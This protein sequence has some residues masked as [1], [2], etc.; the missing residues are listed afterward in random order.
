MSLSVEQ[1]RRYDTV[2][3][4][5]AKKGIGLVIVNQDRQLWVQQD[6]GSRAQTGRTDGQL[7]IPFETQKVGEPHW[8]N[9]LGALPEVFDDETLRPV[10]PRLYT[11]DTYQSSPMRQYLGNGPAIEYSLAVAVYDGPEDL[12]RP[13]MTEEAQPFG[14]MTPGEMLAM[15]NVRPLAYDAITYLQEE[16]VIKQK[17]AEYRDLRHP[18]ELFV[19]E[20]FVLSEFHA[21]REEVRDM[22]PGVAYPVS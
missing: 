18:V 1:S 13:G 11:T 2:Q 6:L 4:P 3:A 8:S 19:P 9:V 20:G 21:Q 12:F 14:W 17:L 15:D 16:D 10:A 7:S 5:A 22:T